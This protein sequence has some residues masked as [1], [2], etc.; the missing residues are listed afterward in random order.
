MNIWLITIGEQLPLKQQI[1][2]LRTAYLAD[3]LVKRGHHVFWWTSAFDHLKKTWVFDQDTEVS[4][5]DNFKIKAL[6]GMGYK[7]NLSLSRL[8]D[9]RVIAKKFKKHAKNHQRPDIIV[10]SMPTYD[11]AH[12][13]VKYAN[14]FNIPILIDIRDRWPDIFVD[15]SPLPKKLTR[16]C[17][18]SEF[19][20]L[21]KSLKGSTG[22]ISVSDSFMSW[23]LQYADRPVREADQVFYL[24]YKK[25]NGSS[26]MNEQFSQMMSSLKDK[27]VVTF[28]G[29]FEEFHDPRIL[30]ECAQYFAQDKEIHF[31]LAGDGSLKQEI[32]QGSAGLANVTLTGWL[33]QDQIDQLLSLSDVG[34]CTSKHITDIFP[35]KAFSYFAFGLPVISAFQGDLKQMIEKYEIGFYYDPNDVRSLI[36]KISILKNKHALYQQYSANATKL[37]EDKCNGEVIYQNYAN[38]IEKIVRAYHHIGVR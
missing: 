6:K 4:V 38:H 20:L 15:N 21:V 1:R 13:A 24:G 3:E 25:G 14:H 29:T 18:A 5:N 19:N 2:K 32:Q 17:L 33:D 7:K 26:L 9:H 31:V 34:V 27:F 8:M 11:L 28:I 37:Y 12:E 30:I 16:A 35:N 22:I 23:G 10:V 36:D